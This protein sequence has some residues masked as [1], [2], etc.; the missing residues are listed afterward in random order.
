MTRLFAGICI[1]VFAWTAATA[2][3]AEDNYEL[4]PLLR[5]EFPSTGDGGVMVGGYQPVIAN[6]KCRTDFTATEPSGKVYYNT[7]EFDAMPVQG[8]ILCANGAWRALDGSAS[9]T[10][11][12]QVF[13]KDGV[14]R[15]LP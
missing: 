15:G 4:W 5:S 13:F 9:G 3:Q 1:A 7:V 8:G 14:F 6:G 2:A 11:P 12:Y 10:T